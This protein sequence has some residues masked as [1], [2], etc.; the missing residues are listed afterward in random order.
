MSV[1]M[2]LILY[3]AAEETIVASVIST[4]NCGLLFL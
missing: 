4:G 2:Y 1:E 3:L